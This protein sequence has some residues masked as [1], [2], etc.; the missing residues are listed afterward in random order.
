MLQLKVRI[1]KDQ[2]DYHYTLT[3]I[4]QLM[5]SKPGSKESYE[6]KVLSLMAGEYQRNTYPLP[7]VSPLE[8]IAYM[9]EQHNLR[10]GDLAPL[11]GGANKVS[12]STLWQAKA[13]ACH[14]QKSFP[15]VSC[16]HKRLPVTKDTTAFAP[17]SLILLARRPL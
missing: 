3:R 10:Q 12:T 5:D 4:N 7:A 14:D 9:M 1:I 15:E 8:L 11:M 16:S 13:F 2:A 6:L 17:G